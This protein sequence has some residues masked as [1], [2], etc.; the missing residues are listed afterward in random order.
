MFTALSQIIN[1]IPD[2]LLLLAAMIVTWVAV[3]YSVKDWRQSKQSRQEADARKT[4]ERRRR[5]RNNSVYYNLQKYYNT[6]Q[7]HLRLL[8]YFEKGPLE[9]PVEVVEI[10]KEYL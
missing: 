1:N 6:Q 9:A 2:S 5:K 3:H 10:L 7:K 8:Q 4:N